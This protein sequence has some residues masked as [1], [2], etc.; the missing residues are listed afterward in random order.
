MRC[1]CLAVKRVCT[2]TCSYLD[3]QIL[4]GVVSKDHVDIIIFAPPG[5]S[6]SKIIRMVKGRVYRK[7]FEEFPHFK[8]QNWA[9]FKWGDFGGF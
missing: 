4:W 3:F 6:S 8:K 9:R 2:E 5:I 1:L 7:I